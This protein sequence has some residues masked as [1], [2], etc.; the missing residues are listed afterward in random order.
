M[1]FAD[2]AEIG[3]FHVLMHREYKKE[4]SPAHTKC[5][6]RSKAFTC[7]N[8]QLL[9]PLPEFQQKAEQP[10]KPPTKGWTEAALA[11]SFSRRA[12]LTILV[13]LPSHGTK[14]PGQPA[15]SPGRAQGGSEWE[16]ALS[17]A[18]EERT[19]KACLF[20]FFLRI[21]LDLMTRKRRAHKLRF[22]L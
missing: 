8:N 14:P 3:S 12:S 5:I 15:Q 13:P 18:G 19:C 2:E 21:I 17:Q 1:S 16:G 10:N 11:P 22:L 4:V 20:F 7:P 6:Y 9:K